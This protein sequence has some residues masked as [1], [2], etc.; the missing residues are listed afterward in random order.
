MRR[1]NVKRITL[2][3]ACLAACVLLTRGM[4]VQADEGM[5]LLNEPPRALLKAK[6]GFDL[7]GDWLEHA[8]LASIRFNNGGSGSFVSPDGLI[9]T[10]HHIGADSLQKLSSPDRNLL[11]VS[12]AHASPSGN[13]GSFRRRPGRS[14]IRTAGRKRY[15][16]R[17]G[18]P[19][20]PARGPT[21]PRL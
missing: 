3:T 18:A 11:R 1:T 15:K 9:I 16:S 6:Y 7:T 19:R 17:R 21:A 2:L 4:M 8:R 10:N 14:R 13:H 12:G 20:G 5:W